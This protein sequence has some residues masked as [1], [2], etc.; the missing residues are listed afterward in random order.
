MCW[1]PPGTN[2]GHHAKQQA[3][4]PPPHGYHDPYYQHYYG[5]YY[6]G[7]GQ[8][9]QQ[10]YPPYYGHA[11]Y[12]PPGYAPGHI[13]ICSCQAKRNVSVRVSELHWQ[14]LVRRMLALGTMPLIVER[15]SMQQQEDFFCC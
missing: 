14:G 5:Q 1:Q 11:P 10:P 9:Y 12:Y 7:Y 6:P 8:Y 4:Q 13:T 15:R 2:H 3:Y